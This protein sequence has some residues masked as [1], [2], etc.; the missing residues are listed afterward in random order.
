MSLKTLHKSFAAF[1]FLFSLIIY[2]DT[3]APTLSFWDCGE[4]IACSVIMGVPHPPGS[5][6]YL[7][8][9]HLFS[10]LP[11]GD[12]G[13]RVNLISVLVTALSV[14]L[15]YLTAVRL[16]R[17]YR[18]PERSLVDGL[19]N[20][21]GAAI[22][23]LVLAFTHSVWFNAVEAEVYGI[24]MFFTAIVFYL[25]VR[26]AD[27]ADE[28]GSDRWLLLI[29]YITGL[30]IGVH[31]LNI[32][33]IPAI[34]LVIYFRKREFTWSSFLVML[35]LSGA[36]FAVVYP[37]IVKYLPA[38]FQIS[39]VIP[40]I[41]FLA[42]GAGA[43]YALQTKQRIAFLALAS[44]F[45]IILG[46]T[47]YGSIFIRS[48]LDPPIDENNPDTIERFLS[49]LNREQYGDVPIMTRR[50]NNDPNYSSE[51]DFFWGYQVNYMYNRYLL[52]Q[53]VG[54]EGDFQGAGVDF[55]KFYALPLLLGL[56]GLAYHVSRDRKRALVVLTLFFMTGYAIILYLN[57]DNPQPRERDYAYVGSFYA[58]AVW[59]AIGAQALLEWLAKVGRDR[60]AR[61]YVLGGLV[62]M[63]LALPVNMLA[64][65]YRMHDR[66]G[67]LV[68][69]DYSRN[70]LETCAPDAL[71][72][73]NGDNDTFPLW[74]LQEVMG[75]RQDVRVV[76]LSLLNT[77]WYIKQLKHM[78]PQVP[79]SFSDEYIDRYLDQHDMTALRKRYWPKNDPKK[80]TV[81]SIPTPDGGT[82]AWDVPATMHLP[83][84][85]GDTGEPNFL[86]V[87]DIMIIDIV[88]TNQWKKPI[89]FAVTVSNSNMIGLRDHLTMEGLAFRLNPVKGQEID[90]ELMRRNL[91]VTYKDYYRNLDNPDI[92]YDDN[93]YRLLQNYRSAFLQ[94]ATYY[95]ERNLP[96]TAVYHGANPPEQTLASFDQLSDHDKVLFILDSMERYVP[97][98]VIP[99]NADEITLHLGRL[100]ADLGRPE[101]LRRR[102]DRLASQ[103][104]LP[105]DKR[106]RYGAV[107]LQWLGDTAAAEKQFQQVLTRNSGLEERLQ[108]ATAYAQMKMYDQARGLLAEVSM[109]PLDAEGQLRVGAVYLQIDQPEQAEKIFQEALQKDPGTGTMLK[110]ATAYYQ[111][112]R[113]A[114]AERMFRQIMARDPNNGHAVGGLLQ[115]FDRQGDAVKAV[116]LLEGW[117]ASHPNDTGARNQLEQYRRRL[118]SGAP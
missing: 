9:G 78:D 22:G 72:F 39:A 35:A 31:L 41:I 92:H 89:Y 50:W 10:N 77:G 33:A 14:M 69:W 55:S 26:W 110:V 49:Y 11:F 54:Q 32:L 34:A 51:A 13:W 65:S 46:Y 63:T 70:I 62:L 4:F 8:I 16:I 25:I 15:L 12:I 1:L 91:L 105:A 82:I 83:T 109:Q 81:L 42:V 74:Y 88:A 44:A 104:N 103:P 76:N 36:G 59:I 99:I 108:V 45:L 86:R 84:G 21:G 118:A 43:W 40:V 64:K 20:Y 95:L 23:A 97:E 66:S 96:G 102:M 3:V 116:Q 94:L 79:I 52:W 58:F 106:Y 71:I 2:L 6:L 115:I 56:F 113:F 37:G 68:A 5:P 93:V 85:Q 61:V 7:L 90:P 29:A 57:Q 28:P 30:A 17:L 111:A 48:Q 101:E 75:V 98:D 112:A 18:G 100:Y 53:F 114:E 107:Y 27:E 80:P 67:N 60:R 73:T 87:Q 47:T 24:S 117:V 19:I 38:T